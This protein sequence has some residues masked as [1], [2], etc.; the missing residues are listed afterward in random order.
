MAK[1]IHQLWEAITKFTS[2]VREDYSFD[3]SQVRLEPETPLLN[4][5]LPSVVIKLASNLNRNKFVRDVIE[6]I[7]GA[8]T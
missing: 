3:S 6:L 1:V 4:P 5:C 8:I 7:A 2:N